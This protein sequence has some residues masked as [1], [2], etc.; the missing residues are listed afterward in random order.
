[1]ARI[2]PSR[3]RGLKPESVAGQ[4]DLLNRSLT[5]ARIETLGS[6]TGPVVTEIAPS[7]ERE[8]KLTRRPSLQFPLDRSLTG[9]QIETKTKGNESHV[10]GI[11]PSRRRGLKLLTRRNQDRR[12]RLFI[13]TSAG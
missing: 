6:S 2:A 13:L 12:Y 10:D 11:A 8:L 7:P 4:C 9:A 3:E 5:V 1:M